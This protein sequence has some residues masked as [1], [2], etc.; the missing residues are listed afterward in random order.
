MFHVPAGCEPRQDIVSEK[1]YVVSIYAHYVRSAK[2][3]G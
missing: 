1:Q 2:G 3:S